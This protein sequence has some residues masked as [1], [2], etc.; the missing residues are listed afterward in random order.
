MR[1]QS[2]F[3]LRHAGLASLV[4]FCFVNRANA[5]RRRNCKA[6]S[7][8]LE[9]QPWLSEV[10]LYTSCLACIVRAPEHLLPCGHMMCE[11]CCILHG[12]TTDADLHLHCLDECPICASTFTFAVRVKP[13]TAGMRVLSIDGGGIRAVIPIQFLR[14]LQLAI[15][16]PTPVQE[17]FDLSYGTSSGKRSGCPPVRR[18][19]SWRSSSTT[20]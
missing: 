11:Q 7:F 4:E 8:L 16:L 3:S 6:G 9:F 5:S 20:L 17:H 14:A 15:D 12:E 19:A 10:K 1:K 2:S 13:A 18:Y